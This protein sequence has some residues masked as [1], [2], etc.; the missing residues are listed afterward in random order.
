MGE[1]HLAVSVTTTDC[2]HT[3]YTIDNSSQARGFFLLRPPHHIIAHAKPYPPPDGITWA[4]T[5]RL[6]VPSLKENNKNH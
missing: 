2:S 4:K 6:F 3:M 5:L 1:N